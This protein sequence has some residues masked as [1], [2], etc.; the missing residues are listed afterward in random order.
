[1]SPTK[2][3]KQEFLICIKIK[4]DILA[5]N[6]QAKHFEFMAQNIA[7]VR[8]TRRCIN[9]LRHKVSNYLGT[10]W[11]LWFYTLK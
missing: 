8:L 10:Q 7:H 5:Y 2:Y 6:R 3:Q 1:M 9:K 4:L 11:V